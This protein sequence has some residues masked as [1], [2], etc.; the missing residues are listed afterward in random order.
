MSHFEIEVRG[1]MSNDQYKATKKYLSTNGKYVESKR[2]RLIDYSYYLSDGGV[3]GRTRDIRLRT[4]NGIPEII[5]KVG[6]WGGK[7]QRK[8]F[9]VMCPDEDFDKLVQMFAILGF[10]RGG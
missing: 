3:R 10:K 1:K 4:T 8:E 9:S 6:Q 7:D 2:R 5:V